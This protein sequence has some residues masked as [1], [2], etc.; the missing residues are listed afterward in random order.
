[1]ELSN[2]DIMW[3]DFN[4]VELIDLCHTYGIEEELV[5]LGSN[6]I[7]REEIE[8]RLTAVEYDLSFNEPVTV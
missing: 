6:L 2:G 8:K 1:M 5:V 7:N 3:S 4:D